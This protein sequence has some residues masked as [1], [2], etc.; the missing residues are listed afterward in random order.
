MTT[1][2]RYHRI[3]QIMPTSCPLWSVFAQHEPSPDGYH[4]W[5][6]R[7]QGI[8]LTESWSPQDE[9]DD[10]RARHNRDRELYPIHIADGTMFD[11]D[12]MYGE[13][14]GQIFAT[15]EALPVTKDERDKLELGALEHLGRQARIVKPGV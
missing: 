2:Q 6:E 13:G 9:R 10:A 12:G 15:I 4:Y 1:R 5:C 8:A 14:S 7:I 11:A 3:V